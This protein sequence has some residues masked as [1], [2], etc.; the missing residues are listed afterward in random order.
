LNRVFYNFNTNII[1]KLEKIIITTEDSVSG[2]MVGARWEAVVKL[3]PESGVVIITDDN[4]FELYGGSFPLFP[5]LKVKPGEVSKQLKIIKN[6][7]EKLL[8]LGIDRSGFILA[9]GG[10]VVCD[11]AG[12]LASVYMRGIRCGYVSTTLLS[13]VDAST[14]GKNGVNLGNIKNVIGTFRQPEF[15][16][17]DTTM[18]RTLPDDEYRSGLAELI[19]TGFIGDPSIIEVLEN[20]YPEVIKRDRT[21]L[22]DLVAKSVK[23]KGS[24]VS[25]DEKENNLRR[26]LNFGHTFGHAIE[27][28]ESVK[29]GFAVASGMELSALFSLKKGHLTDSECNRVT[30]LLRKYDLLKRYSIPTG[31]IEELILHDKKKSGEDIHFVFLGGIGKAIVE[32]LPVQ[33]VIDFYRHN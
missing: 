30:D 5:V 28:H 29:H 20:S 6:L 15:V 13:Q 19:K 24:I 14:G 25:E 3:L 27:L 8:R 31:K 21:L 22:S 33:E 11:V 17:C 9:I 1:K 2:I 7:S 18:L 23:F 26:I 16:I 10:G 4:V 32:I 12:F